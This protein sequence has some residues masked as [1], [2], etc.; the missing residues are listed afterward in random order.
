MKR[1]ITI[2]LIFLLLFCGLK[3]GDINGDYRINEHDLELCREHIL[4]I[5]H[6]HGAEF[7]RADINKDGKVDSTDLTY[8]LILNKEGKQ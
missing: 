6:L 4:R 8:I 3:D 5:S 2:I 7:W 1:F